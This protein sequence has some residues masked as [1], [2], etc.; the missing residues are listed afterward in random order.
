MLGIKAPDLEWTEKENE[1]LREWYPVEGY[2]VVDRLKG[3][4]KSATQ[5]QV[6]KLGLQSCNRVKCVWTNEEIETLNRHYPFEGVSVEKQIQGKT[7]TQ[8]ISMASKLGLKAPNR[9]IKNMNLARQAVQEG[10]IICKSNSLYEDVNLFSWLVAT[11]KE[12]YKNG[13]LT[14]EEIII[15]EK[16]IGKSLYKFCNNGDFVK[17]IDIIEDNEFALCKSKNEAARILSEKF[18]IKTA[19]HSIIKRMNG[20]ITTPYKGRFMFYYATDE[21]IKQ[22]FSGNK[23]N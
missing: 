17:I 12:K 11:V 15:I 4:T 21:E 22:Y 3:R 9:F 19:V 2:K 7:R 16:L 20:K 18:N 10:I 8:I 13:E 1:I 6:Y 14:N 5:G 23:A